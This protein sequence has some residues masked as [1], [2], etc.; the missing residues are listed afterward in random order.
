MREPHLTYSGRGL[1]Q[2]ASPVRYQSQVAQMIVCP[3][4]GSKPRLRFIDLRFSLRSYSFQD[5]LRQHL[6]GIKPDTNPKTNPKPNPNPKLTLI[7]TLFSCF[8]LFSSTV[9]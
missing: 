8:M 1:A 4:L 3:S 6:T 2:L 7:L 5:H 9:L